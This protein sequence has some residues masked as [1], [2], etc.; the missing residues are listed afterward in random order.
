MLSALF[1]ANV[2]QFEQFACVFPSKNL[3]RYYLCLQ[4]YFSVSYQLIFAASGLA[5]T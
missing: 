3:N 4:R 2:A 1:M 5:G